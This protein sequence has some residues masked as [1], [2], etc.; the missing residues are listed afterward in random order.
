MKDI[1]NHR[2]RGVSTKYLQNYS[3]WFA[4]IEVTKFVANKNVHIRQRMEQNRK[5]WGTYTNIENY[6][7]NL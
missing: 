5:A 6:Y 1:V 3:N 7:R 4:L 2:L